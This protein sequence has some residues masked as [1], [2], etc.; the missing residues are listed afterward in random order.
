MRVEN[1]VSFPLV[2]SFAVGDFVMAGKM[3]FKKVPVDIKS[4]LDPGWL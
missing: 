3:P 2:C 4:S 1:G